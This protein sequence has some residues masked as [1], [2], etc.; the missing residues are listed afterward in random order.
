MD[1]YLN[2]PTLLALAFG[3]AVLSFVANNMVQGLRT[4][5]VLL[6]T[7]VPATL[8]TLLPVD[9]QFSFDLGGFTLICAR[10]SFSPSP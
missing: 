1:A 3:G 8:A 7:L 9:S 10:I 5:V 6:F 4:P 2:I